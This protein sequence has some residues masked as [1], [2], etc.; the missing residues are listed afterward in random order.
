MKQKL[1]GM[2]HVHKLVGDNTEALMFQHQSKWL[3]SF[4]QFSLNIH[5][6]GSN[7]NSRN[8]KSNNSPD[9]TE[10]SQR[11]RDLEARSVKSTQYKEQKGKEQRKIN[12]ARMTYETMSNS[13][14]YFNWTLKA[15]ERKWGHIFF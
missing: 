6:K 11:A 5:K 9:V 4:H 7:G 8:K 13:L 2:S 1:L 3:N 10:Q 15:K 12:K 14:S